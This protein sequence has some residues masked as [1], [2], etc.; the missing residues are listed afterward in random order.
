MAGP[1]LI[2]DYLTELSAQLPA[3]VVEELADG[4]GQTYQ[5]YLDK[6]LDAQAAA[7]AALAEFGAPHVIV[8]A[9]T[10]LSPARLAARRLLATGPAS[11]RAGQPR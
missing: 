3:P 2:R 9:F 6:G 8:A 1:S 11:A 10:R 4:P 5:R 7:S